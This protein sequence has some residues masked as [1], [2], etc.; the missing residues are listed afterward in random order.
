MKRD[1]Y[2]IITGIIFTIVALA[3]IARIAFGW[4]FVIEGWSVPVWISW[5]ASAVTII[6]AY[7]GFQFSRKSQ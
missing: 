3:H 1:V 2:L 5:A 4:S 6:L 7:Y